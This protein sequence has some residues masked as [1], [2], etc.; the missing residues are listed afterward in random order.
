M[1]LIAIYILIIIIVLAL[2][3]S[4]GAR[5]T[6]RKRMGMAILSLLDVMLFW[7]CFLI[8]EEEVIQI[9]IG[10][11]VIVFLS[12]AYC[13]T[14]DRIKPAQEYLFVL[15]PGDYTVEG[16][17]KMDVIFKPTMKNVVKILWDNKVI[18]M[19]PTFACQGEKLELI[20]IKAKEN[21]EQ[22][23]CTSYRINDKKMSV[24]EY[25]LIG[26][27]LLS[28]FAL[29]ACVYFAL[30]GLATV[31]YWEELGKGFL[32]TLVFGFA[33]FAMRGKRV[34]YRQRLWAS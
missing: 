34:I 20:C 17:I 30:T 10:F 27:L 11:S 1:I 4:F 9:G 24:K 29:P 14:H 7:F 32:V 25:F 22:Y 3:N 8:Y 18:K 28:V 33:Y 15:N 31:G 26:S 6:Q 13:L 5:R 12:S 2:K 21:E 16:N 19:P 23:L